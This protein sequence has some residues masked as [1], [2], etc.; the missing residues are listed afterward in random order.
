M[1]F[2][3]TLSEHLNISLHIYIC[4]HSV[5]RS[6]KANPQELNYYSLVVFDRPER[7]FHIMFSKMYF[8]CYLYFF[9]KSNFKEKVRTQNNNLKYC[10]CFQSISFEGQPK[11]PKNICTITVPHAENQTLSDLTC[12]YTPLFFF[13]FGPL[14]FIFIPKTLSKIK[15]YVQ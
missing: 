1:R 4:Q 14:I 5:S 13:F 7:Q 2:L 12:E 3:I 9:K 6:W 11:Q 10:L 15:H 8:I